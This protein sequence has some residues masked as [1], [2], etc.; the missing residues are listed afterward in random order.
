MANSA[1]D[2][3]MIFFLFSQETGS[4][5]SCKLSWGMKCQS[6]FPEKNKKSISKCH[7]LKTSHRVQSFKAGPAVLW[8]GIIFQECSTWTLP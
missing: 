8:E 5:I 4:D 1:D 6:L 7:L 3:L 2:Q